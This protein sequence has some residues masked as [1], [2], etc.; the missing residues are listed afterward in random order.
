MRASL[1][2]A[3]LG[4]MLIGSYAVV[5]FVKPQRSL[6]AAGDAFGTKQATA[7]NLVSMRLMGPFDPIFAGELMALDAGLFDR[8]GVEVAVHYSGS[9]EDVI[10]LVVRGTDTIGVISGERFLLA[11][12]RGAPI[13]ALAAGYQQSRVVLYAPSQTGIRT[14][15]QFI[16][17]RI[18]YQPGQDTAITYEA[19]MARLSL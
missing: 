14:P 11:R 1:A 8:E 3:G 13:T 4:L 18:G 6:P 9:Q 15:A 5:D 17:K 10:N 16:G 2:A 19:M 7:P 12:S